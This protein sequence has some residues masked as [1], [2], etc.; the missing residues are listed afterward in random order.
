MSHS[1]RKQKLQGVFIFIIHVILNDKVRLTLLRFLRVNI[2]CLSDTASTP[3]VISSRQKLID[4]MNI[5]DLSHVSSQPFT[6][7]TDLKSMKKDE[8]GMF[9]EKISSRMD[10]KIQLFFNY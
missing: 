8:K 2:C 6:G 1:N 7:N 10:G 4:M 5:S 3:S 9:V